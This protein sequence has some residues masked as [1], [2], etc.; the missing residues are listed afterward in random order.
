MENNNL[1]MLREAIIKKDNKTISSIYLDIECMLDFKL[2]ALLQMITTDE[3]YGII[4]ARLGNYI[5]RFDLE[6]MKYFPEIKI[7]EE[8]VLEVIKLPENSEML[9][10]ISPETTV[11]DTVP[12]FINNLYH[13]LRSSYSGTDEINVT[14]GC[15]YFEIPKSSQEFIRNA[16]SGY[17]ENVNV[18]FVHGEYGDA[19]APV[20]NRFDMF[21]LYYTQDFLINQ[22]VGDRVVKE[23]V[24]M[25]KVVI[26]NYESKQ[27]LSEMEDEEVELLTKKMVIACNSFT[28]FSFISCRINLN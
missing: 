14:I 24:L 12:P 5:N 1:D 8:Q 26:A 2:G 9:I 20:L 18:S 17:A 21:V 3:D 11:A 16:L 23:A 4:K 10:K 15:R 13:A 7:T 27:D 28:T 22:L 6:I 19:L 25:D